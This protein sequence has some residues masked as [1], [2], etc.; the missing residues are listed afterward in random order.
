MQYSIQ[1]KIQFGCIAILGFSFWFLLGFPFANHNESYVWLVSLNKLGLLDVLSHKLQPVATYRPLGQATAWLGYR[2]SGGTIYPIELFNYLLAAVSWFILFLAIKEKKIFSFISL[3]VGVFFFSGYIYLFHLH[4][5]FYS[6]LLLLI[7]VMFFLY[8]RSLSNNKLIVIPLLTIVVSLFHPFALLIFAAFISGLMIEKRKDITKKQFM[9]AGSF[10]ILAF[11]LLKALTPARNLPL[12]NKNVLGLLTSYKMVEVNIFVSAVGFLL[13]ILTVASINI[14]QRNKVILIVLVTLLS[15][16]FS[17]TALPII[18]VWILVCLLKMVLMRKW[19]VAFLII[20][21]FL[22]PMITGT[23][24]PTYSIF[25]LMVC[26]A[27]VP[28]GW[29]A[30]E[31]KLSFISNKFALV[32]FIFALV[33]ISCLRL[34]VHLPVISELTNPILAEKEKTFQLETIVNWVIKSRYNEYKLTL[35]QSAPIPREADNVINRLHRPPT[36]QSCLKP[37]IN[38]LRPRH[39]KDRN[40]KSRLIVCFGDEKIDNAEVIYVV[41]GK[42]AGN[43]IVYLPQDDQ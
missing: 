16:L 33:I 26:A 32:I 38:S 13:S 29:S 6:P 5:V 28:F 31:N 2:L 17:S 18:I 19:S 40:D 7:A 27:A 8:N 3:T 1:T 20:V 30:L 24:S 21:T 35:N 23:G 41:R 15:L 9:V 22:L 37:Y 14:P 39:H 12:A 43:A 11:V 25:V 42:F 10:V 4:G 34:G 36:Q